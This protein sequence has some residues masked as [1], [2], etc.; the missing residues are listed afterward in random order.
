[1]ASATIA[2]LHTTPVKGL[3][4]VACDEIDLTADGAADDRRFYLVDERGRMVNGKQLGPLTEVV[5]EYRR[6]AGELELAFPDGRRVAAAI[7][8]GD[9]IDTTF[10]SQPVQARELLG[11]FGPALSHHVG[12]WVRLV[13]SIDRTG[14]D[15]GRNGAVSIV[16]RASLGALA[17]VAG[18][19]VD[20]RRFRMLVEVDGLVEA[21]EED[22]W[23]G[24]QLRIGDATVRV[25]GHVGRCLT[26]Q[27]HPESGETDLPTL[28]LLRS[29]RGG[30][31]TT[32]PLAFGV[33]GEVIEPGRVAVG[34]RLTLM[35]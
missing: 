23:V 28:N 15:R 24:A 17:R 13:E 22:T 6:A 2:A 21:H 29:Y 14:I 27:R 1:M 33:Y 4:I 11:P 35:S 3:R 34:D 10:F 18:S 16:S 7:E 19:A 5:A 25:R 32:E 31:P 30:L 26:T 9:M 20:A 8:L 12:R